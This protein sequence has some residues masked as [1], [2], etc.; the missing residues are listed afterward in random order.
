MLTM[1]NS[2]TF[3]LPER[4]LERKKTKQMTEDVK[5]ATVKSTEVRQSYGSFAAGASSEEKISGP[6]AELPNFRRYYLYCYSFFR[7]Q[8]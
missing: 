7:E 8:F 1:G 2:G 4:S 3:T 5:L 6:T